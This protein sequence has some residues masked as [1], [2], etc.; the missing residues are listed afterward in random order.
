MFQRESG[1]WV[2]LTAE[3]TPLTLTT[4]RRRLRVTRSLLRRAQ[5]HSAAQTHRLM[6]QAIERL[7][8]EDTTADPVSIEIGARL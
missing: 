5:G 8:R 6:T 7:L 4:R 2:A 3:R 1:G